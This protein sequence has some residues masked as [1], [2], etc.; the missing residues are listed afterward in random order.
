MPGP[1]IPSPTPSIIQIFP[2]KK[3]KEEKQESTNT[4]A[5]VPE[6]APSMIPGF[7]NKIQL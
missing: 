7:R 3:V 2:P 5:N 1:R 4:H 6:V